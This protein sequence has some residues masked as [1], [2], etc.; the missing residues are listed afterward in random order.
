[1]AM[2]KILSFLLAM[3]L[4]TGCGNS[5]IETIDSFS[6]DVTETT[7]TVVETSLSDT[8]PVANYEGYTFHYITDNWTGTVTDRFLREMW[9]ESITGEP[10]NDAVYKRNSFLTDRLNIQIAAE[11]STDVYST[12]LGAVQAGEDAYQLV[13]GLKNSCAIP[14]FQ[15][16]VLRDWNTLTELDLDE[17]WWNAEAIS[18]LSI[19]GRQYMMSGSILMSEIDD[20][21][22]L[23]FN[24]SIGNEYGLEN[25]Y[26]LVSEGKWT[27]D[28]MRTMVEQVSVDLDGDG[29]M[30]LGTD[31]F[32]YAQ[33]PNSMTTNW[34]F[35]LDL[36]NGYVTDT[37]EW[38]W[39]LDMDAIATAL[40]Q[41]SSLLSSNNTNSKIGYYDGL[42]IFASGKI[43]IYAIILSALEIIREMEDDFGILP[44]PKLNESQSQYYNHI[45]S[46]SP[47]LVIPLT[48][49]SDDS[50]TATILHGLAV[51]SHEYVR[52][53]YFENVLKG[54]L[55]RDPQTQEML[56]IIWKSA[57]YDFS[58]LIGYS[59][60]SVLNPLISNAKTEFASAWKSAE[61]SY[62]KNM[63]KVLDAVLED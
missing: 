12:V 15:Q 53:V 35:S 47:I 28:Q 14:L 23:V 62:T 56:D 34:C 46:A 25:P 5:T 2:K 24:K 40:E 37:G 9:A 49:V 52:P 44:Y 54:K 19:Q 38:D 60:A 63:Q 11:D 17:E 8:I 16:G 6:E 36:L 55:S 58:Y 41:L 4:L 18:K 32:G 1:M 31:L 57:T 61:T 22:A 26:S 27:L 20:T 10:I 59:P 30:T 13:G 51:S 3:L 33:D 21:L 45:G 50:R 39:A 42:D 29:T 7:P 48:N 43:Y